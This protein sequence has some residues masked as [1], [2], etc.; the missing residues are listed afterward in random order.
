M[1]YVL[2][3]LACKGRGSALVLLVDLVQV[4]H[5]LVRC[6][7]QHG[8]IRKGVQLVACARDEGTV[9]ELL[10]LGLHDVD[11]LVAG[12]AL[13][14]CCLLASLVDLVGCRSV[15]ACGIACLLRCLALLG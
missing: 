4:D 10:S 2:L 12:E 11:E 14:V 15:H 7:V 9:V 1:N 5:L 8:L 13:W 3:T 6:R